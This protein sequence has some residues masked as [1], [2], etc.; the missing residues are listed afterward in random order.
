[1][2]F[3]IV[4]RCVL[5][6]WFLLP[7]SLVSAESPTDMS[8]LLERAGK[9]RVILVGEI[10]GTAEVPKLTGDLAAV[11]AAEYTLIVGLEVPRDEQKRIDAFLDSAGTSADRAALLAGNFWSR[12]YQ[13]GRSSLAMADLLERLRLLRSE[14]DIEVLALDQLSGGLVDGDT[15]DRVM[16]ERLSEALQADPEARALV[17]AG[18]FHTRV[19]MGAPWNESHQFLGYRLKAF[20]PYAIE[21]LANAGSAWTC[22]GADAASCEARSFPAQTLLPGMQLGD[23]VGARGHH[24][25]WRI[26]STR[27]SAPAVTGD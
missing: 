25:T 20:D 13:D 17:L 18:N 26:D 23:E 21:V 7:A 8:A 22:T 12:A 9:S 3:T 5:G 1:M 24:G 15:R 19:Q 27:A 10:H 2:G 11:I 4:R 14:A 16:A 6:A